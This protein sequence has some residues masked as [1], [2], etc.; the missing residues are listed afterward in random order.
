MAEIHK[1]RILSFDLL[2]VIAILGVVMI[3]VISTSNKFFTA[4]PTS[5]TYMFGKI[6]NSF[7]LVGVPIFIMISGALI[8][9]EEK[10][11]TTRQI[12]KKTLSL[13][14]LLLF[15]LFFYAAYDTIMYPLIR[16]HGISINAFVKHFI[17]GHYHLWFLYML[18]GLYL[19]TP[20][21]RLFVKKANAKYVL[22]FIIISA[23]FQF[24]SPIINLCANDILPA[25]YSSLFTKVSNSFAMNF[26]FGYTTYFFAGWYIAN[27]EIKKIYRLLLYFV[28]VCCL[29]TIILGS[30]ILDKR[31]TSSGI[32]SGNL[33]I[34]VLGLSVGV[35][36]FFYYL[37]KDK[38]LSEKH[39]KIL[40]KTSSLTFGVYV[41]HIIFVDILNILIK[42]PAFAFMNNFLLLWLIIVILS[43]VSTYII[44]FIPFVKKI[45]RD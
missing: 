7:A 33:S 37:L 35:F 25:N 4:S 18:I 8:L 40:V 17:E 39:T 44:S 13:V 2:R 22:Y 27:C 16:N 43:F 5:L 21:F 45:I 20:I 34:T 12:F 26:T 9:N 38:T 28:S 42:K 3:H 1:K 11:L 41:I 10:T 23:I 19:L 36:V 24:A 14:W 6:L 30:Y 32:L 29:L 31:G 15:W